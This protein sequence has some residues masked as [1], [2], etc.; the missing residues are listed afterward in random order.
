M[1]ISFKNQHRM[2][3][4]LAGYDWKGVSL[5]ANT[6]PD[7]AWAAGIA[8]TGLS[9]AELTQSFSEFDSRIGTVNSV[10]P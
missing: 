1:T 3:E 2:A 6:S 7:N 4:V 9:I 10:L 8:A 5:P